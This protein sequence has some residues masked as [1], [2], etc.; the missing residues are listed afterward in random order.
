VIVPAGETPQIRSAIVS[1]ASARG[2]RE[3]LLPPTP[4][5]RS[6][7]MFERTDAGILAIRRGSRTAPV[8]V[9]TIRTPGE[10]VQSLARA[11]GQGTIAI[12]WQGDRVIPLETAVAAGRGRFELWVVTD[13]LSEVP[14]A[15]G[16]L[17]HGADRVFVELVRPEQIDELERLLD[18]SLD[19]P[20]SWGLARIESVEPGGLGDRVIV[21]L[22]SLLRAEEGLL[23]GSAAAFLFHVASEA[24]GSRYT[25]PREFRVN[26]G[27]AH[28]YTLLADGSTRYL[29]ELAP[30]DAVCVATPKGAV[31]SARVGRLKIERRPMVLVRGRVHD[32]I[33]TVF[34]QEAETVALSTRRARVAATSLRAGIQVFGI[35]L[36]AARHLGSPIEESIEER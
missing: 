21:D 1:R 33:R 34:L 9:E 18:A 6:A 15:L 26:A 28:S 22:T 12:R 5:R 8:R 3:F 25:R 20:L 13:R 4:H 31:R 2:F 11:P 32:R 30:G 24:E 17:Q 14:A 29:A 16:A 10:L 35:H 23:I 27:A 19:F 36:P 7:A